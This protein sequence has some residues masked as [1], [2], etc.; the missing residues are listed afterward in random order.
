MKEIIKFKEKINK[1]YISSEI[2]LIYYG[3]NKTQEIYSK[4][5]DKIL[6]FIYEGEIIGNNYSN[7]LIK[8]LEEM[9]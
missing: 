1:E 7:D 6:Q 5:I 2:G 9:K 8:K 3:I 4:K